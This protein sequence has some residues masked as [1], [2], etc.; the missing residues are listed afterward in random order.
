MTT[1]SPRLRRRG[2]A[3]LILLTLV[4]L[5]WA[6]IIRPL[7]EAFG[8]QNADVK[9][10]LRLLASYQALVAAQPHI[11]AELRDMRQRNA[12]ASGLVE[13][14]TTALAAAK[15]QSDLKTIVESNGGAV[16]S[17]QNLQPSAANG[18][19]KIEVRYDLSLPLGSL[20]KVLYQIETHTPYVF[21]VS[22]NMR[23]PQNWQPESTDSPAPRMEAQWVVRGYR[24]VGG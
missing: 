21:I 6:I 3:V 24:W 22:M 20:R 15:L 23:M 7:V 12:S 9:K 1:L 8:G 18:F 19:E 5:A 17:S 11:E 13:G 2:L 16:L 10:S 14:S 4:V